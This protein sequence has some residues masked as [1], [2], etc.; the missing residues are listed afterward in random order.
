M[1]ENKVEATAELLQ[2]TIN[3]IFLIIVPPPMVMALPFKITHKM[4]ELYYY[5][6][7]AITTHEIG[8]ARRDFIDVISIHTTKLYRINW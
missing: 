7:V 4:A 5:L 3:C 8:N 2:P 1:F 6:L